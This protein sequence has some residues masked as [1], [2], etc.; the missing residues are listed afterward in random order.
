MAY[1]NP[2]INMK[3]R[4]K[5]MHDCHC[6]DEHD[7]KTL[8]GMTADTFRQVERRISDGACT[9]NIDGSLIALPLCVSQTIAILTHLYYGY[10]VDR[11]D[12]VNRLLKSVRDSLPGE[13]S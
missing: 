8:K 3:V 6:H 1:T 10:G 12:N 4:L 13:G 9:L 2:H 5:N 11:V 7:V